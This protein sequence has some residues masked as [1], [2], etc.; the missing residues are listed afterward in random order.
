MEVWDGTVHMCLPS[1]TLMHHYCILTT[2][3]GYTIR[4]RMICLSIALVS[5]YMEVVS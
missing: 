5:W 2:T 3:L 4:S 1:R